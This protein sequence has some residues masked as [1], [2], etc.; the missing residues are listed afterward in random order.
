M[1][2]RIAYIG[3]RGV[4]PTFGG[5]ERYVDE[6]V[7]RLPA[8][9]VQ[10]TVYC[11]PHYIQPME[12][13]YTQQ[14]FLPSLQMKGLEAF[15]HSGLSAVHSAFKQF[16]LVHF[17]ALGP[18][19]F[20]GIP[21]LSGAKTVTTIHG[22]DWQ[23]AKWAGAAKA[24]LKAG[25]WMM[26]HLSHGIISVSQNLKRR[27]EDHYKREVFF[28]PIGFS[29]PK[30]LK[31]GAA[32]DRY[33][34]QPGKYLFFLNRIVPEKGLH[35][36]IEAFR[37]IK[38]DDFKF[39]ISGASE[40][41]DLYMASLRNQAAGDSRIVF[42]GYVD[43]EMVHELYSNAYL[44]LLPSELEG[45]PAVLLEAMSH[46]CPVLTSDIQESLDVIRLKDHQYGFV[47]KNKDV[48]DLTRQLSSLMDNPEDVEAMRGPG[49]QFVN[50]NYSWEKST[51]M[52][53]DVY[54]HVL[55]S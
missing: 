55:G 49:C 50:T 25:D 12:L 39:V 29:A 24:V 21:R 6:I 1:S 47:H 10:S 30:R 37:Q 5:V 2:I 15:G 42:T 52:T 4:P 54:K 45:M 14:V 46:G 27:Y 36:A 26:G 11:R 41:S 17:Q 7:R 44:F 48:A 13:G 3:Q 35:Y 28:V 23:R 32:H 20:C 53:Y 43:R 9:E 22:I 31:A 19:L 40:P 33:D 18:A 38:R 8:T 51:Q 34:L 16:D